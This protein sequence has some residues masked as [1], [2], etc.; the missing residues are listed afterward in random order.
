[1][2]WKREKRMWKHHHPPSPPLWK[3]RGK[4]EDFGFFC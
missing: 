1:M 3:K 2:K 4:E